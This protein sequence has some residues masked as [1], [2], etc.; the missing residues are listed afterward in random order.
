MIWVIQIQYNWSKTTDNINYKAGDKA[1]AAVVAFSVDRVGDGVNAHLR[2][3]VNHG[4]LDHATL[5]RALEWIRTKLSPHMD[6]ILDRPD[7]PRPLDAPDLS[8][9]PF[10]KI[11]VCPGSQQP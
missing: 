6:A 2:A 4:R 7:R 8:H 5:D 11:S 10:V 1:V 9:L 3:V